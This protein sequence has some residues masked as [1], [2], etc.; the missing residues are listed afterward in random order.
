MRRRTSAGQSAPSLATSRRD[1][2]SS[3]DWGCFN[4][5]IALEWYEFAKLAQCTPLAKRVSSA[6]SPLGNADSRGGF[7]SRAGVADGSSNTC[8]RAARYGLAQAGLSPAG[9]H[10]LWLAPSRVQAKSSQRIYIPRNHSKAFGSGGA[11]ACA[12]WP[13]TVSCDT[14]NIGDALMVSNKPAAQVYPAAGRARS[15]T[16][17]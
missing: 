14:A 7:S 11:C 9:L 13:N 6:V 1:L 16:W 8:H 15:R 5:S 4:I 3:I 12:E 10:Q 2:I 17:Q